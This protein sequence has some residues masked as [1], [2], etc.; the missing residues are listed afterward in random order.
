MQKRDYAGAA[1]SL[2]TFESLSP[3][4]PQIP[5]VRS[6]LDQIEKAMH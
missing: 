4:D 6:I 5:K 1:N 3:E 2:V